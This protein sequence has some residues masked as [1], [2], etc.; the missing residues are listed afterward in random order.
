MTQLFKEV[1]QLFTT[2]TR[3]YSTI[4]LNL[5]HVHV[6]PSLGTYKDDQGGHLSVL[7]SIIW[8]K[9]TPLN[10]KVWITVVVINITIT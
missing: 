9:N 2:I 4:Y 7:K 3:P 1:S 5:G 8:E 10:F 6:G